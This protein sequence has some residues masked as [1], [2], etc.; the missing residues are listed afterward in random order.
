MT[1]KKGGVILSAVRR[2][3][4]RCVDNKV[5]QNEKRD[6]SLHSVP[7]RMTF[8]KGGVILSAVRRE[9]FL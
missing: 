6:P 3:E 1:F 9:E 8:K 7:L 4:S 5:L 2:E